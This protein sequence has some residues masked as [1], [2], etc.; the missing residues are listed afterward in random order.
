[1]KKTF[2]KKKCTKQNM[3]IHIKKEWKNNQKKFNV[4]HFPK[5]N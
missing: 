2:I 3:K 5:E 4:L 1:M